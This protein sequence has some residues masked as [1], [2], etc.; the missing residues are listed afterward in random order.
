VLILMDEPHAAPRASASPP[1]AGSARRRPAR[2]S[3]ASRRSWACRA[4]GDLSLHAGRDVAP[5][6]GWTNEALRPA[7]AR[8]ERR[9]EITGVTADSRK[10][11]PGFL[12]AA[13]PGSKVDGA[14]SPPR[15]RRRAPR[16]CGR[17]DLGLAVPTIVT[18]DPRRAYALAAAPVLGRAAE[19]LLAVTGTNGKTSVANFCRQ[20]FAA[21]AD[22]PPAW[23][24]WRAISPAAGGATSSSRPA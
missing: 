17:P 6:A 7:A 12:F 22:R 18:A 8:P 24:R 10:A 9:P 16:R 20:M 23:A 3:S 4:G 13:L 14:S 1:A 21:P 5:H 2:S 15:P 19:D 11:G